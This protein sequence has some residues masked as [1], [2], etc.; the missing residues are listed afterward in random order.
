M[1]ENEDVEFTKTGVHGGG[2]A[3]VY[4]SIY[5]YIYF[6]IVADEYLEPKAFSKIS[7]SI[8]RT[9]NPASSTRSLYSLASRHARPTRIRFFALCQACSHIL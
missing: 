7:R 5:I 4:M 9:Y 8:L 6:N 3:Y 1:L 2:V